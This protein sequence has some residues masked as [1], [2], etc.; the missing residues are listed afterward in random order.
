V[1]DGVALTPYDGPCTITVDDTVIDSRR[2]SCNVTIR[3]RGVVIRNSYITGPVEIRPQDLDGVSGVSIGDYPLSRYSLLIEDS[4]IHIGPMGAT[5]LQRGNYIARRIEITG[6]GRSAFCDWGC[7]IEDSYIH[8]QQ[9]PPNP[10]YVHMSGVRMGQN[11][12]LRHNTV[13]CEGERS[14]PNNGCSASR[15]GYG[16][17]APV[18]NNLIISNIFYGRDG[19]GATFC[20]RG[21]TNADKPFG[22]DA[23]N[24]RFISNV[25]VRGSNGKCGE[26]DSNAS[27]DPTRPGNVWRDNVWDDGTCAAI[28]G[29]PAC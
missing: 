15:T 20:V 25:F 27:F 6:G 1:P 9:P 17:W 10:Q 18:Q 4:E 19:G 5:G 28:R 22:N 11:L 3:A 13:S 29:Q 24:V 16:D 7:T 23:N 14:E 8:G 26:F 2:M 12:V 21:G